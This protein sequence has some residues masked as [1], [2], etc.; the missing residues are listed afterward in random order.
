MF[1]SPAGNVFTIMFLRLDLWVFVL[2]LCLRDI[3]FYHIVSWDAEVSDPTPGIA[4]FLDKH[5]YVL[6]V[7]D[8]FQKVSVK[9]NP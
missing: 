9:Y 7:R 5:N 1:P 3:N 8:H 6:G 4:I 2:C